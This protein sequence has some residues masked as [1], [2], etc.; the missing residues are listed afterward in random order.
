MDA[1]HA[2]GGALPR[3]SSAEKRGRIACLGAGPASLAAAAELRQH[4]YTVTVFERREL[5]GG[6]N[7][8]GVAEYKLRTAD[9]L[10]EIELIAALGVEFRF[11]EE[12]RDEAA[13][14]ALEQEYDVIFLGVGLGPMHRLEI[15]GGDHPGVIDALQFI[16][17]YKLG[18]TTAVSGR[19]LVVGAGNTAIDAANAARRLGASEVRILY[20]RT[21]EHIS[22]F[23]REY[24]RAKREG[25]VFQWLT[26][27]VAV[28]SSNGRLES[29]ECVSMQMDAEGKASPIEGS[30]HHIKCDLILPAIGQSPL[31]EM[32][33]RVRGLKLDRGIVVVDRRT[34]ETNNPRYFAAG[35][36][37]N[38]GREVVDAVAE[39][40]RAA[41]AIAN[42]LEADHA[43]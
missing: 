3:R 1:F 6:L 19:V 11:G 10:R 40:K 25:I 13:L 5:P 42:R 20:R 39:G 35:D 12:I 34:G 7:T 17:A 30:N 31:L 4:G 16:E 2:G 29:L 21:E 41:I 27:P 37:A 9:S 24:E 23:D 8:Y 15:R 38:G 32:L 33:S 36:C 28:H 22:A 43:G 14:A 26:Q 18:H